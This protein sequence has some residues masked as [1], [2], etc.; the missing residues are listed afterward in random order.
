M[1]DGTRRTHRVAHVTTVHAAG[2]VRILHKESRTLSE[3]GYSVTLLA[4]AGEFPDGGAVTIQ[5]VVVPASRW[6]RTTVGMWRAFRAARATKAAI[7]HLH[8]PELLP[9]GLLLQALGGRV[10]Y[11]AHEDLPRDILAKP[12]LLPWLRPVVSAMAAG[13]E[14]VAGRVLSGVVAATPPI[15]RRFPQARTTL[16]MNYPRL[17]EFAAP[18]A[19]PHAHR[20]PRVLYLGGVTETRGARE[21]L[22]AMEQ[23]AVPGAELLLAGRIAPPALAASLAGMPAWSRTRAVGHLSRPDVHSA[24]ASARVGLV[25]LHDTPAY[26]ESYPVKLFEYMAAGLPVVVSDFPLWRELVAGPEA[27]LL[28]DPGDATAAGAAISWLLDHPAEAQAM[29]DRGRAAV[30]QAHH[31]HGEG[32]RLVAFYD[33]LLAGGAR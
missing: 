15:A 8:D 6:G 24:L 12:Y 28:V 32:E 21:M 18:G 20:A 10:I 11:D 26:R 3:A 7:Y 25:L 30:E 31:W 27:G 4:P 17:E 5:P 19:V 16:V 23:V 33:R 1:S 22:R 9:M 29:G 13:V 2:D 14:W